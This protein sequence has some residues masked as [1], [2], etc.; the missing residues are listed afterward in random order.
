VRPT[1]RAMPFSVDK[2]VE[3]GLKPGRHHLCVTHMWLSPPEVCRFPDL[4]PVTL[5]STGCVSL[6][7]VSP[8]GHEA[9]AVSLLAVHVH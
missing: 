8:L 3:P 2:C 4:F 7:V 9:P 5:F 6:T 1:L